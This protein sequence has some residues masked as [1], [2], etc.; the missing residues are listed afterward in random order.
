V[1]RR[2]SVEVV[3]HDERA[4]REACGY[5]Q[6]GRASARLVAQCAGFPKVA[7]RLGAC[8]RELFEYFAA[9][10]V[11]GVEVRE[12]LRVKDD[13]LGLLLEGML[14]P[15][16]K[17][18]EFEL[19]DGETV[20]FGEVVFLGRFRHLDFEVLVGDFVLGLDDVWWDVKRDAVRQRVAKVCEM[21][22]PRVKR[23]EVIAEVL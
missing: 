1:C 6:S 15:R 16:A 2:A 18:P 19:F 7:G 5:L 23:L 22:E 13:R 12:H 21:C 3:P 11:N 8:A 9:K 4:I 14:Y 20:V 10:L 17:A